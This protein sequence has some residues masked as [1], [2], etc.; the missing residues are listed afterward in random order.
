MIRCLACIG[1]GWET[2]WGQ[3][4]LAASWRKLLLGYPV[5]IGGVS[6]FPSSFFY[7]HPLSPCLSFHFSAP[8]SLLLCIGLP[9]CS[10]LFLACLGARKSGTLDGTRAWGAA[11]LS[12]RKAGTSQGLAGQSGSLRCASYFQSGVHVLK[13]R[14]FLCNGISHKDQNLKAGA[15]FLVWGKRHLRCT[16]Q[17][18]NQLTPGVLFPFPFPPSTGTGWEIMARDH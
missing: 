5:P 12:E 3:P 14:I 9:G 15:V 10:V 6:V 18:T 11:S 4:V 17:V 1:K 16:G 8:I 7:P 13:S 2:R